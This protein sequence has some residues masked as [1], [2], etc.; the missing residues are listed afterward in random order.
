MSETKTLPL[1]Y[2]SAAFILKQMSA[3]KGSLNSLISKLKQNNVNN[4]YF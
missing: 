3:K 2:K 4:I 1:A